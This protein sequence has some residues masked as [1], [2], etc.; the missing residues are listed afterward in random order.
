[1]IN[2]N[3]IRC[4]DVVRNS[5]TTNASSNWIGSTTICLSGFHLAALICTAKL[6]TL[7][8]VRRR[9]ERRRWNGGKSSELCYSSGEW[10][11]FSSWSCELIIYTGNASRNSAS[12]VFSSFISAGIDVFLGQ[13]QHFKYVSHVKG[14]SGEELR[15]KRRLIGM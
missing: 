9:G 6:H 13:R 15:I 11:V 12:P 2:L 10:T 14:W 1:M 7:H 4:V 3:L 8:V 5:I